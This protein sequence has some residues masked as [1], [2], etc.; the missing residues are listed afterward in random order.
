MLV[1]IFVLNLSTRKWQLL[2]INKKRYKSVSYI[3]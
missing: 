3:F 2:L 1:L